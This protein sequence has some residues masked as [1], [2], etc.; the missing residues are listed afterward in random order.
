[1]TQVDKFHKRLNEIFKDGNPTKALI[2]DAYIKT[3]PTSQMELGET[4]PIHS[5]S[6]QRELLIGLL[7]RLEKDGGNE[8]IDKEY[9]V[10]KYLANL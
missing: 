6:Q 10:N 3:N 7:T 8:W 5:V 9:I 4:L 1:M 2:I